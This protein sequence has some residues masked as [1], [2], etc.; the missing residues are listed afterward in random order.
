MRMLKAAAAQAAPCAHVGRPITRSGT[1]HMRH[2][3]LRIRA[4]SHTAIQARSRSLQQLQHLPGTY[5][6]T[7]MRSDPG[8]HMK[9]SSMRLCQPATHAPSSH[10]TVFSLWHMWQWQRLHH[11]QALSQYINSSLHKSALKQVTLNCHC[12]GQSHGQ[13]AA[14]CV[15]ATS[16]VAAACSLVA[17]APASCCSGV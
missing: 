17:W 5:I 3:A 15:Y 1:L 6:I 2:V 11:L 7:A 16:R 8:K 10:F 14:V 9:E 4:A 12:P 13:Q